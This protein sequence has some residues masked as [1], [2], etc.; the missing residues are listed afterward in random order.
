VRRAANAKPLFISDRFVFVDI[1]SHQL[2]RET[3]REKR[4]DA[5]DGTGLAL[6]IEERDVT[7]GRGVELE[8]LGNAEPAL[9]VAPDVGPKPIAAAHPDPM[10]RLM[11]MGFGVQQVAAKLA[12]I[13]E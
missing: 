4:W 13:L 10:L 1:E 6:D 9:E 7:F 12:D 3:M 8:D 5:A 11:W 2:R